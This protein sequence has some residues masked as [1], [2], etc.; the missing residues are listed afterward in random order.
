MRVLPSAFIHTTTAEGG[1]PYL[2]DF[3]KQESPELSNYKPQ[4][5]CNSGLNI[6]IFKEKVCYL[7]ARILR[8]FFCLLCPRN[9]SMNIGNLIFQWLLIQWL[10]GIQ[11]LIAYI[12]QMLHLFFIAI[13]EAV[14]KSNKCLKNPSFCCELWCCLK[15]PKKMFLLLLS[16]GRRRR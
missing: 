6:Y 12:L 11:F 16:N 5:D 13:Q 4:Y 14:R 10:E 2:H 9:I 1:L 8:F 3:S 7:E 15:P